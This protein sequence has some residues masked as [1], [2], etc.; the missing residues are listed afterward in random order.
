MEESYEYTGTPHFLADLRRLPGS[1]STSGYR[2]DPDAGMIEAGIVPL[3]HQNRS[4]YTRNPLH[5]QHPM[6]VRQDDDYDFEI[7][8]HGY[9]SDNAAE[10]NGPPTS[11]SGQQHRALSSDRRSLRRRLFEDSGGPNGGGPNGGGPNGGTGSQRQLPQIPNDLYGEEAMRE[12]NEKAHQLKSRG[13]VQEP[14]SH[15]ST[16]GLRRTHDTGSPPNGMNNAAPGYQS[17]GSEVS[18]FSITSTQSERPRT[19]TTQ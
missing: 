14:R 18:N 9:F 8:Q 15:R 10:P 17:D 6:A 7:I 3:T 1:S 2:S 13:Y 16:R 5:P 12:L 4:N 19:K 11:R